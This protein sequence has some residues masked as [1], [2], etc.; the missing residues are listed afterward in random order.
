L[1]RRVPDNPSYHYMHG[2]AHKYLREWAASLKCNLRAI[3]LSDQKDDASHWNAA[4][5]ATA[6]GDWAEARRQWAHCGLKVPGSSGP[7]ESDFG[8]TCV[9]LNPWGNGEVMHA[10][11]IDP[12]RAQLLNV[13]LPESGF[14]FGDI[15]LH[16]GAS[17]G[18]RH[19]DDDEFFVFNVMERLQPSEFKTYAAFITC[20]APE[21]VQALLQAQ[22]PGIGYIEDWT[23]SLVNLCLRCSYGAP[24]MHTAKGKQKDWNPERSV[25][26]AAQSQSSVNTILR[27][28]EGSGRCVDDIQT[29]DFQPPAPAEGYVWWL[30]PEEASEDS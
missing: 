27:A 6:L 13:P 18:R 28:W 14:Q 7:I 15:V 21:D 25:G 29:H 12:V 8:L 16:D 26:I 11:R 24:H 30:S 1:V 22:A 9:R 23:H 20:D 10:Q 4:I 3:A 19:Y 2:L 5:A 17:T